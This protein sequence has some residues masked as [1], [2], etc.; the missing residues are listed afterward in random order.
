VIFANNVTC[1]K[2]TTC[3]LFYVSGSSISARETNEIC[4]HFATFRKSGKKR[5]LIILQ[6]FVR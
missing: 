6:N 3:L 1:I 4:C 5:Y 2:K